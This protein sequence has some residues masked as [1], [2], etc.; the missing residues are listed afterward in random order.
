MVTTKYGVKSV[1]RMVAETYLDNPNCLPEVNHKDSNKTNNSVCNL[2]W[3]TGYDNLQHAKAL[4][5]VIQ[6]IQTQEVFEVYNLKKWCRENP[7]YNQAHLSKTL[8][9][10]TKHLQHKGLKVIAVRSLA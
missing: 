4:V 10:G 9:G 8:D 7:Q 5:W 3:V 2:E 1:H 6:N